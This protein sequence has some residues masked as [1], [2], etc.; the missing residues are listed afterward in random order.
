MIIVTTK[1]EIFAIIKTIND[2]KKKINYSAYIKMGKELGVETVR[3]IVA[4][5]DRKAFESI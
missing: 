4:L 5:K 1:T 2:K 3:C